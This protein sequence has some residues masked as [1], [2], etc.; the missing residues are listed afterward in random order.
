L[1]DPTFFKKPA[2]EVRRAT[3]RYAQIPIELEAAF[4]KWAELEGGR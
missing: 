1:A 2:D 3:D 4:A